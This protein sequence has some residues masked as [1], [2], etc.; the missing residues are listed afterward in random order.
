MPIAIVGVACRFPG[1]ATNPEKLWEMISQG[2]D[3]HSSWPKDRFNFDAFYHPNPE[4]SGTFNAQGGHFLKEFP[5]GFDAPFFNISAKEAHAMDPQQRLALELTYE[6]LEN[7]GIS[8][9][10]VANSNTGS[11]MACF[12]HDY[13]RLRA[14]DLELDMPMYEATGGGQTLLANRISWYFD[15]KG[16]SFIL[17]SACSSSLVALHLACQSIR[18]GETTQAVVGGTCLM[19]T[20][21][22]PFLLSSLHFLAPDGRSKAFDAGADGYGRGEGAAMMVVKRLDAALR[23]GNVIRAVIRGTGVN[24]DGRT[25]PGI[26]VPSSKAQE[27]LIR[28]TYAAAGLD[29]KDT[30]YFEAHGTGT[31]VGDPLECAAIGATFGRRRPAEQ[32][33]IVVG[34]I[35]PNIGHLEAAAGIAGVIK[36]LL[37]VERGLIPPNVLLKNINPRIDLDGWNL[38]IPTELLPWPTRGPRRV[39]VNSFGYG[40]TNA[41]LILDSA[42]HY[43]Q[44]RGLQ[45]AHN[46]VINP[47]IPFGS[48]ILSV[49]SAPLPHGSSN[50]ST[51]SWASSE[52]GE[53]DHRSSFEAL[54]S[55]DSWKEPVASTVATI[56]TDYPRLLVWSSHEQKGTEVRASSF[57][58]YLKARDDDAPDLLDRLAFT[59]SNKRTRFQWRSFAV[60]STIEGARTAL[61]KPNKPLRALDNPVLCF[62]FNGQGAQWYAMGRELMAYGV[63]RESLEAAANHMKALGAEWDLV[64]ELMVDESESRVGEP[65][66]SQPACTAL[67]VALVDLL[68][69]W[70]VRPS[71]TVGHSSGEIAAAYCKG[72]F[73]RET[74]WAIAF[75]RGRLSTIITTKGAMLAVGLGESQT[76]PYIERVQHS[77][78]SSKGTFVIA[79]INSPSSVTVSGDVHLVTALQAVL[80][81][82]R[83]FNRKL[84]VERA[85]HSPHMA[86]IANLYADAMEKTTRIHDERPTIKSS[87]VR[88]FS[89]VTG[90]LIEVEDL[91]SASYW[92][93]NLL[94]PVKFSNAMLAALSHTTSKRRTTTKRAGIVDTIVEIGPHAALQGSI[95]QILASRAALRSAPDVPYVSVLNRKS[96]ARQSALEAL[97]FL[98]Q[99]GC[100]ANISRANNPLNLPTPIMLTDMPPITW[101]RSTKY[102]HESALTRA[103]RFR[104]LP[105]HDLLG[106]RSEYSSDV[107][108]SWRNYLRVSELPWIE[109]HQVQDSIL[110]PFAGMVVMAVEAA[111]QIADTVG[112]EIEGFQ[113]RDISA[114]AALVLPRDGGGGKEGQVE[115]KVQLRPWRLGSKSQD[116]NWHEFTIASRSSEGIWTQNCTGLISVKYRTQTNSIFMDETK[117]EA[118]Q[119]REEYHKLANSKLSLVPAD[120]FYSSIAKQGVCLGPYFQVLKQIGFRSFEAQCDLVVS[121]T[122]VAMPENYEHD[123]IIH[124]TTL[125]GVIQMAVLASSSKLLTIGNAQ[126]PRFIESIYISAKVADYRAGQRMLG[127][128]RSSKDGQEMVCT[129]I[130]AD[131]EWEQ[132]LVKVEG[133]LTV[134]LEKLGGMQ[135]ATSDGDSAALSSLRKIG[136]RHRWGVDVELTEPESLTTLLLR[137]VDNISEPTG[138]VVRDLERACYIICKRAARRFS[139]P[140]S[141]QSFSTHHHLFF[142]YMQRQVD[143]ANHRALLCQKIDEDSLESTSWLASSD[144]EDDEVLARVEAASIDGKLIHKISVNLEKILTGK[145]EPLQILREDNLLGT[146]YRTAL[147]EDRIQAIIGQY[148][149]HMTHKR[150]LRILEVG[151]GTGATTSAVLSAL[152]KQPEATGRVVSYT[153][154]DISSGFFEQAADDFQEWAPLMDFRVLNIENDPAAQGFDMAVYDMVIASNVLHAT[155]SIADCL[156]HCR[157]MLKPGGV[158]LLEEVTTKLARV[159]MVVGVLPGWWNGENDGRKEGPLISEAEWD[160][161]L[162]QHGFNGLHLCFRDSKLQH[163]KSFIVSVAAPLPLPSPPSHVI[164]VKP[165]AEDASVSCLAANIGQ[166]MRQEATVVEEITLADSRSADL[167]GKFIVVAVE[168]KTPHLA[169]S[170]L[171]DDDFTA[172]KSLVLRSQDI[173]WLTRGGSMESACPEANSIVGVARTVRGENPNIHLTTLDLDPVQELQS[174]GT[175]EI[176]CGIIKAKNDPTNTEFE[177]AVRDGHIQ[178][179]RLCCSPDLSDIFHGLQND[180]SVSMQQPA[181]IPL[182]LKYAGDRALAL[183]IRT[184][185]ALDTLQYVKDPSHLEPLASNDIE[186]SVKAVALNFHDVMFA[187]GNVDNS[188]GEPDGPGAEFSGVITRIGNS[189]TRHAIGDRVLGMRI[190]C[191]KTQVRCHETSAQKLPDALSFVEAASFPSVY[192][193]AITSLV[194]TARLQKGESVLIHAASG[195]FGQASIVL[196]QHLGAAAIY[197]TVGTE[198]KK[199]LLMETY[200]I[201]E[202]HILNSRDLSFA[203]G[204]KRL[205]KGKG[206]DV[207][208]NSLAG[209]ALRQ[210]WLCLAPFGRFIELGRQDMFGNTGLDMAPLLCNTTFA[211]VN[212]RGVIA[213]GP[214]CARVVEDVMKYYREGVIKI[215]QPL[216][217]MSFAQ[218]EV[219]FRTMQ[220]GKHTGKIVLAPSPDDIVPMVL[221]KPEVALRSEGTYFLPGGLGGLGRSLARWMAARG[222]RYIVFT[223]RGGASK[224]EAQ[225]L[226]KELDEQG[227]KT[228]AY[229]SNVGNVVEFKRVLDDM[230]ESSFPPVVGTVIMAMQIQDVFFENMTASDLQAAVRPKVDVT[231]NAHDLLPKH[232]DFFI[233]LSSVAGCVGSRGQANYNAGNT[234]QD[235]LARHRRSQGLKSTSINLGIVGDVGY[236]ADKSVVRNFLTKGAAI[237]LNETDVLAAI[238]GAISESLSS[239]PSSPDFLLN[240]ES[241]IGLATGGLIK[242]GGHDEPYWFHEGR[243]ASVKVHDTQ[244]RLQ[245]GNQASLNNGQGAAAGSWEDIRAALAAAKTDEEAA[246]VALVALKRKLAR[247][248]MMDEV[249]LDPENAANAYGIDSLVAVEIR[250]WVFK[251]LRSEVS[252]FEILS[253]ASLTA[254]AGIISSRSTIRRAE[255]E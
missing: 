236:A 131:P 207:I 44:A 232:L 155:S 190:G 226:L 33:N 205:T 241:V 73:S 96:E 223:S 67:Q 159:P 78:G 146:Y 148:V 150:P 97:G 56:N 247:A 107:E 132:P 128:G 164:L 209:E 32:P 69:D 114:G 86:S 201:P 141:R 134:P 193:T 57:L 181:A 80:D 24:Q 85:Y 43:L 31:P 26:T 88:M 239:D 122:A 180:Q 40:G 192:A 129:G 151:A 123:H 215:P 58:S 218:T 35:K 163:L 227:V 52:S 221:R 77:E 156:K 194:Y 75:H 237:W 177:Y 60:A 13:A 83:I 17:D 188:P 199:K 19:F 210:T 204:I 147:G 42:Y 135:L 47:E 197:C 230:R 158:L 228:K 191:W 45:G 172:I 244:D 98:S 29:F 79:C 28:S 252:V 102:W 117:A 126:I 7:A 63:Y 184:P 165:N 127:Y 248:V 48:P 21:E 71:V 187:M 208:L 111:R 115:T 176:V 253:N 233:C 105:R 136:S 116:Y 182:P 30:Q 229:A 110:Y 119:H 106:A 234:F 101:N 189:V 70:G 1:E 166:T 211:G 54:G 254:L 139:S 249:D 37:C 3:G 206:V 9:Q 15:M 41:H 216:T 186:I 50:D 2:R 104:A 109:D 108:P 51:S 59:L 36:A 213:P 160:K 66:I 173:L 103:W 94:N 130:V 225:A 62:V 175:A 178:I 55:A 65:V 11:Y 61:A 99:R 161:Q 118:A 84:A 174:Q 242:A 100:N 10:D 152:G 46:T 12:A 23:D 168:V 224:P 245:P 240:A 235:A 140:E 22:M 138:E 162:Q 171:T 120:E 20:P 157:E 200:G 195:G 185:G 95:K 231:K 238:S 251:E 113:L 179:P 82:E 39:S 27:E 222:A 72:A 142:D 53:S 243:F 196:A 125:D 219:A 198:A 14:H 169:S 64:S 246:A 124:P 89:S 154:T 133:C 250:S 34:S 8:I 202:E 149:L 4:R 93:R 183:D 18:A 90:E 74:A 16:P 81:Q 5:T 112:R 25:T 121:D 92:V 87:P 68:E 217:V 203:A 49:S 137:S 212:M 143:R 145:L 220:S 91:A 6:S 255:E 170:R 76:A 153:F 38:K 214:R 144:E 167:A